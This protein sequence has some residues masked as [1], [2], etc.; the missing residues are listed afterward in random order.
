MDCDEI[1]ELECEAIRPGERKHYTTDPTVQKFFA[2][3]ALPDDAA[4][5]GAGKRT[6]VIYLTTPGAE[7][8]KKD[9]EKSQ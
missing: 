9:I 4:A 6:R 8:V 1:E 7:E 5:A 2:E 3:T